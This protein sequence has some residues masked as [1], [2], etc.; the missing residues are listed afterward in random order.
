MDAQEIDFELAKEMF[1]KFLAKKGH[2]KT[3]ERYAVLREVYEN[4][5]LLDIDSLHLSM[6]KKH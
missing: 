6:V 3:T 2:K 4:E 5:G 1:T